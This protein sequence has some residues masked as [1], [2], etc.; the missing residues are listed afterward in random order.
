MAV[1]GRM[2]DGVC[3]VTSSACAVEVVC[4]RMQQL[5][6]MSLWPASSRLQLLKVCVSYLLHE[7]IAWQC[8]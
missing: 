8:V 7:R 1:A 4:G 6:E 5:W 2:H 3:S